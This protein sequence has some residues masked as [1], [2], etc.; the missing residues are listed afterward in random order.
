MQQQLLNGCDAVRALTE[1]FMHD[2]L[3]VSGDSSLMVVLEPQSGDGIVSG[4]VYL[5]V[6]N[7]KINLAMH[8]FPAGAGTKSGSTE[9]G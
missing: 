9:A 3:G 2:V 6:Y 5:S 8:P 1:K 7:A 4:I